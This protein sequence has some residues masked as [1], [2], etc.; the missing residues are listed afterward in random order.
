MVGLWG[1]GGAH[2]WLVGVQT[3]TSTLEKSLQ[4]LIKLNIHLPYD[5]KTSSQEKWIYMFLHKAHMQMFVMG[6]FIILPNWEQ[7]Y[8]L[9]LVNG[10]ASRGNIHSMEYYSAER[11][12]EEVIHR[13]AGLGLKV[14][15]L[16]ERSQN[17]HVV[18]QFY[19]N[20]CKWQL[21]GGEETCGC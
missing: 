7:T 10:E 1:P 9:E 15:I 21:Q 12:E 14:I 20:F 13:I 8:V 4:F 17:K 18:T 6:L 16:N 2:S 3:G 5:L 19:T 11:T